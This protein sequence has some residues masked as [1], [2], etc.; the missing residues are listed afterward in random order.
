MIEDL[1]FVVNRKK[2]CLV[3]S[4]ETVFLGF[5]I[6]TLDCVLRLPME[7]VKKD[8]EGGTESFR[9]RMIN[10]ETDCED[11]RTTV[12]LNSSC[13]PCSPALSC[14]AKVNDRLFEQRAEIFRQGS[15]RS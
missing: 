13:F 10:P 6:W 7:K 1:G 4:K 12:R 5:Q 14:S 9:K 11:I 8:Q 15:E 2:S 3:R